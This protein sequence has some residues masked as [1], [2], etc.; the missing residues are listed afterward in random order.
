M[1]I[2]VVLLILA[3]ASWAIV[4]SVVL[5]LRWLNEAAL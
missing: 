3:A 5:A 2:G 4:I 1:P